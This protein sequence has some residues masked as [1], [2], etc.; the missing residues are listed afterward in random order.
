MTNKYNTP[1]PLPPRVKT[2][3]FR[4]AFA[5]EADRH[6]TPVIAGLLRDTASYTRTIKHDSCFRFPWLHSSSD[7]ES[8]TSENDFEPKQR[9]WIERRPIQLSY[10]RRRHGGKGEIL[11][12]GKSEDQSPSI[13]ASGLRWIETHGHSGHIEDKNPFQRFVK[14]VT[15]TANVSVGDRLKIKK[16]LSKVEHDHSH[17][18]SPGKRLAP[19]ISNSFQDCEPDEAPKDR[20]LFFSFPYFQLSQLE[21]FE[22]QDITNHSIRLLVQSLYRSESL[23]SREKHQ[24]VQQLEACKPYGFIHV[25]QFWCLLIGSDYLATYSPSQLHSRP[26]SSIL[27]LPLSG[28][29]SSF[30]LRL[31]RY[32]DFCVYWEECKT[33][34][35]FLLRVNRIYSQV[36]GAHVDP[37]KC[38]YRSVK[39]D[40]EI[41]ICCWPNLTKEPPRY[42]FE[43]VV[44]V[45]HQF[46]RHPHISGNPFSPPRPPVKVYGRDSEFRR[47]RYFRRSRSSSVSSSR[48]L[49]PSTDEDTRSYERIR[50]SRSPSQYRWRSPTQQR[51]RWPGCVVA[52]LGLRP[53]SDEG[54]MSYLFWT[55]PVDESRGMTSDETYAAPAADP[56]SSLPQPMDLGDNAPPYLYWKLRLLNMERRNISSDRQYSASSKRVRDGDSRVPQ[57]KLSP[58]TQA[59]I[60]IQRLMSVIHES[61]RDA[62]SK[63]SSIYINQIK[64][65]VKDIDLLRSSF[66]YETPHYIVSLE[67]D[68]RR[69]VQQFM[70]AGINSEP[71]M[72][73]WGGLHGVLSK[74]QNPDLPKRFLVTV[75]WAAESIKRILKVSLTIEKGIQGDLD[76]KFLLNSLVDAFQFLVKAFCLLNKHLTLNDW[77]PQYE[78]QIIETGT[79]V[80]IANNV[81]FYPASSEDASDEEGEEGE[82]E[83]EGEEEEEE[84]GEEEEVE[85]EDEKIKSRKDQDDDGNVLARARHSWR[86]DKSNVRTHRRLHGT[87]RL[88]RIDTESATKLAFRNAEEALDRAKDDILRVFAPSDWKKLEDYL[89][90][91]QGMITTS[92]LNFLARG[93][94]YP[95]C[96]E[97][98]YR[99]YCSKL[100]LRVR[101]SPERALLDDLDRAEEEMDSIIATISAQSSIIRVLHDSH[102]ADDRKLVE[103]IESTTAELRDRKEIYEDLK[104]RVE[105]MRKQ[106]IRQI[107]LKQ[108]NNSKAITVFTIVTVIFLPLSFVTSYLGMNTV[109][110]RDTDSKQWLFWAV[111]IPVTVSI[112]GLA[113]TMA[114]Q[115][116]YLTELVKR[117]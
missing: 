5:R 47:D 112:V 102:F 21:Y 44:Y 101:D 14:T 7:E 81:M 91:N 114:Y 79:V 62:T 93:D 2:G 20:C 64:K 117:R 80:D 66:S 116:H 105:A 28:F 67:K 52:H 89:S 78:I 109:D 59:E 54:D 87:R 63:S 108:D 76:R 70:G 39:P 3:Q 106:V 6:R 40:K 35:D 83:G 98:I 17:E 65:T 49:S 60:K 34:F 111:S 32:G 68:T 45:R 100:R 46:E 92:A 75:E 24:A 4:E 10:Y 18:A 50:R 82:G 42:I 72:K 103:S 15:E 94:A 113:M 41:N 86:S 23:F 26:G 13:E 16:W 57:K 95:F 1:Y 19:I 33:W 97:G 73:L 8:F 12:L 85:Q 90:V 11:I 58:S 104:V 48:E 22:S 74:S 53:S 96:L 27:T 36:V 88:H 71:E 37:E 25:P 9:E 43:V 69:L 51:C 38:L 107:E 61:L 55:T 31:G 110:I 30:R 84:E 99:D 29:P 115:G 77:R 56:T